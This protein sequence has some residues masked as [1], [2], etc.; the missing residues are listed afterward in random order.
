MFRL[1]AFVVL[2]LVFSPI[3][4]AHAASKTA[5]STAPATSDYDNDRP[6]AQ[7]DL[8][9]FGMGYVDFDKSSNPTFGRDGE[10][11]TQSTDFRLE[12][13]FGYSLW[14]AQNDWLNFAIH[15]LVGGEATTHE[16]LYGFGGLDF[17]LLFWKHFV[18]TESETVG[19]FSNGN[20][21]LM[22][23]MI[24]FR[25]QVEA[26]WKFDNNV[27]LTAQ[28]SHISNAGIGTHNPG[29]EI[30]GGYVHVPVGMIFGN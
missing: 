17:D 15:P 19:L 28:I 18:L 24:E 11:R 21:K 3:L 23:S 20:A 27:R 2:S 16:Q 1:L 25:S 8:I 7:P 13:R 9:S 4:S 29:E 10:A 12:Y 6:L 5:P 26:G 22:G 30:V 14:S